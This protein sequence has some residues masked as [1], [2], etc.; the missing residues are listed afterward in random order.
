MEKARIDRVQ[1]FIL[2]I[3]FEMGT[4]LVTPF[5]ISAGKDA[6]LAILF[7]SLLGCLFFLMYYQLY[8]WFPEDSFTGYV[9]KILGKKLGTAVGYIYAIAALYIS[10]RVLRVFG[11]ALLSSTYPETPLVIVHALMIL[12]VIYAVN[13][14][15]ETIA[16]TAELTIMIVFILAIFGFVLIVLSGVMDIDRILPILEN[17]FVPVLKTVVTETMNVP[18]GEVMIFTIIFP[19]LNNNRRMRIIGVGAMLLSGIMI[20]GTMLINI[21]TLG[22]H[23]VEDSGFP[24]LPTIQMISV[25]DFLERLDV[26]FLIVLFIDVFSKLVLFFYF[27]LIGLTELFGLESHKQISYP[28]GMIVLFCS[29]TIA[30][31]Y[32]EYAY[33]SINISARYFSFPLQVI[34]PL[35]LLTIA[36][37]KKRKQAGGK[38]PEKT[39]ERTSRSTTSSQ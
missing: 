25:A 32:S 20:A 36:F 16:R 11:E 27:G 37:F 28:I 22:F 1:F 14:G 29:L 19:Y 6:W 26:L 12:V 21:L 38:S 8:Q 2:L 13:K 10:S 34:I 9:K 30:T 5:S 3:L 24:L 23:V 15:I 35:I 18:F 33:Q 7:G 39:E 4:S 17:G 31:N